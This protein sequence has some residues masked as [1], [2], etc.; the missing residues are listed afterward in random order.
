M[1]NSADEARTALQNLYH[2]PEVD[3]SDDDVDHVLYAI[4]MLQEYGEDPV[5]V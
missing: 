5:L 3:L 2:D 1:P 4:G